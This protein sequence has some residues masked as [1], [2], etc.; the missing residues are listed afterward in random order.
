ME[1]VLNPCSLWSRQE[2]EGSFP[3]A[4]CPLPPAFLDKTNLRDSVIAFNN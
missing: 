2:A 1:G 4:S 3:P